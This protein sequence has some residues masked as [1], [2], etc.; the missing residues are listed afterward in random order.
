MTVATT[1]KR[2]KYNSVEDFL[3][4]I[5]EGRVIG[6]KLVEKFGR[7]DDIQAAVG[8]DIFSYGADFYYP[9][10]AATVAAFSHSASDDGTS[11]PLGSGARSVRVYG[12]DGNYNEISEEIILNAATPVTSTLEFLRVW[13]VK[14]LDVGSG[15]VNA[16][17]ILVI[18]NASTASPQDVI[19]FV[20]A[21]NGQSE[22]AQYTIPAGWTGHIISGAGSVLEKV[23]AG[24]KETSAHVKFYIRDYQADTSPLSAPGTTNNYESWRMVQSVDLNSRGSTVAPITTISKI[25]ERSDLRAAGEVSVNDSSV[26]VRFNMVLVKNTI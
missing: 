3:F 21:G 14:C 1:R 19:G 7:H 23:G 16:G 15:G 11:S 10:S 17:N 13:R 2:E 22:Q 20:T 4:A 12:L 9:T 25:L 24:P 18:S 8:E 5:A 26:D 6:H